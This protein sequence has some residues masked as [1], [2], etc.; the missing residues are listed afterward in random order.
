MKIFDVNTVG[1]KN[2]NREVFILVC[3]LEEKSISK[4]TIS[5]RNCTSKLKKNNYN[6][7]ERKHMY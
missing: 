4:G 1:A 2:L 7:K 3:N 6:N 5:L